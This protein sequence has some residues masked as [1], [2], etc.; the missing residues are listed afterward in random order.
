MDSNLLNGLGQHAVGV[1]AGGGGNTVCFRWASSVV[2]VTSGGL[3]PVFCLH[4]AAGYRS[5][6]ALGEVGAVLGYPE[7]GLFFLGL[8]FTIFQETFAYVFV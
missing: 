8:H 4:P 7:K 3:C 1:E 2:F 6:L 5:T